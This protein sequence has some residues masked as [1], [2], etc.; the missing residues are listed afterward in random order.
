MNL[1]ISG[2]EL[3]ASYKVAG[4]ST[5]DGQQPAKDKPVTDHHK[6]STDRTARDD[7]LSTADPGAIGVGGSGS[8]SVTVSGVPSMA[9][10]PLQF[11]RKK[12]STPAVNVRQGVAM[13]DIGG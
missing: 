7:M 8:T 1:T 6:Q 3:E 4:D 10:Q 9:D 11:E 13:S 5:L 12:A 2:L